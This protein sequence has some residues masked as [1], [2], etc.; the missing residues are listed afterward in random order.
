MA[1]KATKY[2]KHRVEEMVRLLSQLG[3]IKKVAEQMGESEASVRGACKTNGINSQAVMKAKTVDAVAVTREQKIIELEST[4]KTLRSKLTDAAEEGWDE[5]RVIERIM[6]LSS[7]TPEPPD[8]TLKSRA[9]KHSAGV[10]SLFASDW[11][12]GEVVDP[13]QVA[14]LNQFN[15]AIA[16]ERA[17][18]FV[19]NTIDILT[20]H[21]VNY[22]RKGLVM[23]VGGD[24]FSGDI[25]E[26][27]MATNEVELGPSFIDLEGVLIWS[28]E[29]ILK[30]VEQ[31][32]I[33][34]VTGNHGR[35]TH[36]IRA[37]GRAFTSFDWLLGQ[38]LRKHFEK[39]P[40]VT[41]M[42]GSGSDVRF[43]IF[44][45][46]YMLSHGDQFRG[47][48]GMVG[49]LG[50]IIRGD[51]RKR[52]RAS[53]VGQDYD[54]LLLGHWH[55]LIQL[56]RVIV[57]GCFVA[58]TRVI[59]N[60]GF[61]SIEKIDIGTTVLS[62]DGSLQ[63]VTN[64]FNKTSDT[65]LV[66]LKIRGLPFPLSV[67][68]SHLIWAIKGE[69]KRCENIGIKWDRLIGGAD[70]PQWISADYISPGD[71]VHVPIIRGDDTP[72]DED[73]AWMYGLFLAEGSALLDGGSNGRHNRIALTMHDREEYKLQRWAKIFER[74][75]GRKCKVFK[76]RKSNGSMTSELVVSPGRA[77]VAQFR[78]MF[79]HKSFGK[80][81]PN[82]IMTASKQ[83]KLALF[84]GWSDGDGH[85]TKSGTHSVVTI[86]EKL[87]YGMFQ[88]ALGAG[89][90]PSMSHSDII[91]HRK[92][93]P[94]FTIHINS[95]QET[96]TIDNQLFYRVHARYRD[97]NIVDVYD[98]EVSGEHTYCVENVGVHNSGKGYCEYA[99]ANNFPFE[100][101]Q[102][103]LYFTHPQH[104]ITI[105]MPIILDRGPPKEA[106]KWVSWNDK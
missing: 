1:M 38:V 14:G 91:S 71:Y 9:S 36:K 24:M 84:T 58:G 23:P 60:D 65:G 53:Q 27:L 45:Y 96:I 93:H 43:K 30:H 66:H 82:W 81:L 39:N 4:V 100:R 18:A 97:D 72:I 55:Q 8:W 54:T 101:P 76:R 20:N 92:K 17:K 31:L 102:Q 13:N 105:S 88:I 3:S 49:A 47:G 69:T 78:E 70:S 85:I 37:K 64:V 41:F 77:V 34:W 21:V 33:P 63:T 16:H 59:T 42:I 74:D 35:W 25:H 89:L 90:I 7:D 2:T 95:G 83:L 61:T 10:P 104:G 99:Y 40:R 22:D 75:F 79:G 87:A 50:P 46:R 73:T 56:R 28:I 62:Q 32:F 11:H 94:V 12:W 67:T 80:Y 68:P 103:A 51:H 29:E 19:A 26:E 15:L 98:L 52:G 44:D 57:N 48:D 5:K 86:S 6:D 106:E